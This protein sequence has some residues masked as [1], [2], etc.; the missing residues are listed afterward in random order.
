MSVRGW[1][2]NSTSASTVCNVA[3]LQNQKL[4]PWPK[5]SP[6]FCSIDSIINGI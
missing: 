2:L 4:F 6:L 1:Q 3:R 5:T